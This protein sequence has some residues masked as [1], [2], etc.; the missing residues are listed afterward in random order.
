M[1]KYSILSIS[2]KLKRSSLSLLV[3]IFLIVGC[4]SSNKESQHKIEDLN[5]AA[6]GFDSIGS[7]AKAIAWADA[8]MKA[9]GGRSKWDETRFISWNFFNRRDL[10]WDKYTG[11]VRVE[12][13]MDTA[14]Y[15]VNINDNTGKV[16][17]KGNEVKD[18]DSLILLIN[19]AKSTW[20]NDSYWLVM[21]FKLKDT[22]VTL[23]YIGE[24]N[25]I[26]GEPST[27]LGLTFS[28]VGVTPNNKYEVYITKKDTLVKQWAFF[29]DASQDS[30]SVIWPWDNYKN[31]D[32][33]LLSSDRSD[34][35]GPNN[36]KVFEEL[37]DVTFEDF[38]WKFEE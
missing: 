15:L 26:S 19:K 36:V 21:P 13:P 4:T 37:P 10:I 17:L 28:A 6:I 30:A 1:S 32:G 18:P 12:A 25:T 5:P 34:M 27:I 29:N 9:M 11:Q 38:Y 14:I 24:G 8:T 20:I 35:K 23:K 2:K 33:L 22:G 16:L 31:H 7:D 3:L